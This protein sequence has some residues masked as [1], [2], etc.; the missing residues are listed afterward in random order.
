MILK[1]MSVIVHPFPVF[2]NILL[3][4]LFLYNKYFCE[5]NN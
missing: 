1:R 3:N 2:K 4:D 5:I